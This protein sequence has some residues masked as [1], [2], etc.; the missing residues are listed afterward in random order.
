MIKA[1]LQKADGHLIDTLCECAL[2]LLKGHVRLNP[3]EKKKLKRH[4]INLL[5]QQGGLVGA[6][7]GPILRTLVK[8]FRQ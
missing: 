5:L 7:L 2:N 4:K 8:L 1:V 6:L 3:K